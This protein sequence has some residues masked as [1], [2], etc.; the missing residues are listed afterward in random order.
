[1]SDADFS[2]ADLEAAFEAAQA[3]GAVMEKDP[4]APDEY[5]DASE[6]PAPRETIELGFMVVA[7]HTKFPIEGVVELLG[8][9]SQ[10][11]D[12][13]G[14]RVYGPLSTMT[15]SRPEGVRPAGE[16]RIDQ[17]PNGARSCSQDE[18]DALHARSKP[19]LDA[20]IAWLKSSLDA[21]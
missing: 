7:T 12:D 18:L 11:L 3:F 10:H 14:G 19:L 20:S 8:T 16:T 17:R 9:L 2:K 6:L 5:R 4:L 1:M 13:L 15:Q 21:E